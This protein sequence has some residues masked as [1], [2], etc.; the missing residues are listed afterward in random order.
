MLLLIDGHYYVYRSFHAI[1]SLS[2]SKG[3]PTNAIFGFV[4]TLRRMVRDLKPDRAAVV[5][6]MGMPKRRTDLQPEYK[7]TRAEMPSTMIPQLDFLQKLCPLMGFA[8]IAV[9]DTEADD[10]I[11][12]YACAARAA[13]ESVVLATNDKDLFQLVDDLVRVYSTNKTDLKTPTDTHALLGTF[14][15]QEKWG[16]PPDRIGDVLA[17]V[18]DS[19]DNIPGV[20]GIGIKGA[21]KLILEHGPIMGI[22]DRLD[23]LPNEKMREKLKDARPQ[24]EQNREMVRLDLDLPLP[25]PI[26]NLGISPRYP[27]LLEM[28]LPCEFRTLTAEI[29]EEAAAALQGISPA[30]APTPAVSVKAEPQLK[31]GELF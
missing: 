25:V 9:P 19:A 31:Q 27:E 5:W 15:V 2:N 18:G 1:Q 11:A 8:S 20:R 23:A 6:D 14:E 7:A 4:K 22:L 28:I 24:I 16:V 10:L 17:L 29:R 26:A 3:E 13:G 30:S 21:S 12:S